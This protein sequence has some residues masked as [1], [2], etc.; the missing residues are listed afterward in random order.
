M[1]SPPSVE[2]LR[3]WLL[4]RDVDLSLWGQGPCK[5]VRDLFREVRLL[6]A[7]CLYPILRPLYL[8]PNRESRLVSRC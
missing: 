1:C 4:L 7:A 8:L 2:A 5:S 3:A 6:L